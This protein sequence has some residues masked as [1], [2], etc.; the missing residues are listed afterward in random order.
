MNRLER[1]GSEKKQGQNTSSRLDLQSQEFS[2]QL[3]RPL[4]CSYQ[5]KAVKRSKGKKSGR[6]KEEAGPST[7]YMI[8]FQM[9]ERILYILFSWI[10]FL[11]HKQTHKCTSAIQ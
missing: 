1:L 8:R 11:H 10:V 6:V 3:Q 5:K 2:L 9:T 4:W 7:N